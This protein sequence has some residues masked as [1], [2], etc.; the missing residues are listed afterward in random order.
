MSEDVVGVRELRQN[1]SKY[2]DRVKAG[3]G[4]VVTE[5]GRIVARLVPSGAVVGGYAELVEKLGASVPAE[6]LEAIAAR[7][8]APPLPAGTTDALLAA[9]RRDR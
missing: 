5:H 6:P 2:L 4:L 7:L 8:S 9:D 1:L 3:E